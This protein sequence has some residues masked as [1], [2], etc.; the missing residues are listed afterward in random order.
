MV[1]PLI[2]EG[3]HHSQVPLHTHQTEKQRLHNDRHRVQDGQHALHPVALPQKVIGKK[4]RHVQVEDHLGEGRVEGE[5]V[6][7]KDAG[8]L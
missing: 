2:V 7:G 1:L 5:E 8:N 6:C 4:W 3:S